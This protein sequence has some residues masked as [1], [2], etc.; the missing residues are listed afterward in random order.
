MHV[1]PRSVSNNAAHYRKRDSETVSY[2]N[3]KPTKESSKLCTTTEL[4]RRKQITEPRWAR[5][6][7]GMFLTKAKEL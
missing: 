4:Q 1:F 5:A 3:A 7:G 6:F 2:M